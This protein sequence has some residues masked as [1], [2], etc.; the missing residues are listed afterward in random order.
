MI[1]EVGYCSGIENYSRYFDGRKPGERPWT[2]ID[3]FPKDFITII[4]ESHVTFPQI[5]GMYNGDKKRKE[6]LIEYEGSDEYV[7]VQII[8]LFSKPLD[9]I[10][11]SSLDVELLR[12]NLSEMFDEYELEINIEASKTIGKSIRQ[13]QLTINIFKDKDLWEETY[14]A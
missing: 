11:I 8:K 13:Y 2:L 1:D 7:G 10:L 3:F 6:N 12:E 4:D 5:K 9:R 14:Y